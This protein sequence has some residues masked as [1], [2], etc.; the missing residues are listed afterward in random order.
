MCD[1]LLWAA[2]NRTHKRQP[3]PAAHP[4]C[5]AMSQ[6][7]V[8]C[9]PIPTYRPDDTIVDAAPALDGVGWAG[10]TVTTTTTTTTDTGSLP[11][12]PPVPFEVLPAEVLAHVASLVECGRDLV[13]WCTATGT[14]IDL[15][16][17]NL[18][19]THMRRHGATSLFGTGIPLAV[20]CLAL[21]H[22][23]LP[24]DVTWVGAAAR[25]SRADIIEWLCKQ[26]FR[27][28]SRR[29]E[30]ATTVDVASAPPA[31]CRGRYCG[32]RTT[33]T[34]APELNAVCAALY[35]ALD[36]PIDEAAVFRCLVAQMCRF[37]LAI[38]PRAVRG[39]FS[40]AMKCHRTDVALNAHDLLTTMLGGTC[41]CVL[42]PYY[43]AH[44]GDKGD[45]VAIHRLTRLG[46]RGVKPLSK[47][48]LENALKEG[49]AKR[50]RAIVDLIGAL[51]VGAR[52]IVEAAEAGN[53]D[54]VAIAHAMRLYVC[55]S[56]IISAAA[57][58][59]RLAVVAWAAGALRTPYD[60]ERPPD[61]PI[62]AW[63]T[64][65]AAYGAVQGDQR[66]VLGW[67]LGRPDAEAVVTVGVARM[68]VAC[69]RL[70]FM[71]DIH[72]LYPR[73]F[74]R[75]RTLDTALAHHDLV[76]VVKTLV[77][78]GARPDSGAY[79]QALLHG[80]QRALA[81]LCAHCDTEGLQDAVDAV[82]GLALRS[83][84]ALVW[85]QQNMRS[86]CVAEARAATMAM[87]GD[88]DRAR[89]NKL[90]AAECRCARCS[91]LS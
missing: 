7:E 56:G 13:A 2:Q 4:L 53:V 87:L 91:A 31:Q 43:S 6:S 64:G 44:M 33:Y 19:G 45:P 54:A 48:A 37:G 26:T 72:A 60:G 68:A 55:D 50:V 89:L 73:H 66:G 18:A 81:Y 63:H 24:I 34:H 3:T 14:P 5:V 57:A 62:A 74:D 82:A 86:V 70:R 90:A 77:D 84:S 65:A 83:T 17:G 29:S 80:R 12:I 8:E 79:V 32:N 71:E 21:K 51:P 39:V 67:L 49:D 42:S 88:R 27:A 85:V 35:G 15:A 10:R 69:G 16:L 36:A 25:A 61:R 20:W 23:G 1:L 30:P 78:W 22:G 9:D 38:D 52:V 47:D 40:R 41:G 75:W 58:K 28:L 59:G 76:P 11:S 46:C